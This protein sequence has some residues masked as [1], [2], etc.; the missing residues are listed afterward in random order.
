MGIEI[1]QAIY[2][3]RTGCTPLVTAPVDPDATFL[4]ADATADGRPDLWEIGTSGQTVVVTVHTHASGF[5]ERLRPDRR[6]SSPF[7]GRSSWQ[8]TTTWTV[9][10]TSTWWRMGP[11]RYGP[12][13]HGP[14]PSPRPHYLPPSAE[15]GA[16]VSATTTSTAYPT[17]SSSML[18]T[19]ATLTVLSGSD[20]F[21]G[22]PQTLST[23]VGN[24]EGAFSV[25]DID[26]DGRPDLWFLDSDGNLT[27]YLGGARGDATDADLISWFVE[28]YD[29]PTTR[30]E[31]CPFVP[32][33]S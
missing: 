33:G 25:D 6:R 30:Q 8:E 11:W 23:G 31:A 15:T 10:P 12:G 20:D 18:R 24:H 17:S 32:E 13:R 1:A 3:Y 22:E 21:D 5:S 2:G 16:S 19:P 14:R 9:P 29:Q 4:M 27:S 26:G 7:S 28:G